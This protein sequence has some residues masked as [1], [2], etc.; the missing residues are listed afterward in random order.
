MYLTFK[1][2][3]SESCTHWRKNSHYLFIAINTFPSSQTL[4]KAGT[5]SSANITTGPEQPRII[6]AFSCKKIFMKKIWLTCNTNSLERLHFAMHK[7]Q[8]ICWDLKWKQNEPQGI[9]SSTTTHGRRENET[10]SGILTVEIRW[11]K[12]FIQTYINIVMSN[13]IVCNQP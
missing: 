2:F 12:T 11:I 3:L 6:A 7:V 4:K 10:H 9:L 8:Q 1:N 5:R 13:V